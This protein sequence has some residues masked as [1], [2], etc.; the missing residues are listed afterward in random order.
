MIKRSMVLAVAI[1]GLGMVSPS[2]AACGGVYQGTEIKGAELLESVSYDDEG[3]VTSYMTNPERTVDVSLVAII[4]EVCDD[5]SITTTADP[6]SYPTTLSVTGDASCTADTH[7]EWDPFGFGTGIHDS[8]EG[9]DNACNADISWG[10][11]TTVFAPDLERSG[12]GASGG[13]LVLSKAATVDSGSGTLQVAYVNGAAY[14]AHG[15][16]V[17]W[18][19]IAGTA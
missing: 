8:V 12:G 1:A 6:V 14:V 19:G 5:G 10:G 17:I 18:K 9:G 13:Q 7:S 15:S 2:T 4:A 11:F 3:I 16:G